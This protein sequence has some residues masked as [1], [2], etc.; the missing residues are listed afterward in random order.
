MRKTRFTIIIPILLT[1]IIM[2]PFRAKAADLSFNDVTA[3]S[4]NTYSV[5]IQFSDRPHAFWFLYSE[6]LSM[7]LNVLNSEKLSEA[8]LTETNERKIT[9]TFASHDSD[10]R[11]SKILIQQNGLLLVNNAGEKKAY[12]FSDFENID[13]IISILTSR[14]GESRMFPSKNKVLIASNWATDIVSSAGNAN[15]LPF[16]M[17]MGY[18]TDE[19]T[20]FHFCDIIA[21]LVAKSPNSDVIVNENVKFLDNDNENVLYLAQRGIV[22][23]KSETKFSPNDFL[24]REEAATIFCRVLDYLQVERDENAE[25]F[26]TF[27]DENE[28]SDWA[29]SAVYDMYT[30]GFMIGVPDNRFAPQSILSQEQCVVVAYRIY[31]KYLA[32]YENIE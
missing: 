9:L 8:P 28:I 13:N 23:G 2:S 4:E 1:F 6:D 12:A 14:N 30:E 26:Y 11:D 5:Q 16:Y 21:L 7:L 22:L 10:M 31:E 19:A 27:A 25:A 24:T 29:K 15:L 3:I 18:L 17:S 32:Q 20:R